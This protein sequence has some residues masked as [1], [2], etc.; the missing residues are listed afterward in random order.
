[1]GKALAEIQNRPL[2]ISLVLGFGVGLAGPLLAYWAVM[3]GLPT[4]DNAILWLWL[5]AVVSVASLLAGTAVAAFLPSFL[6]G[7]TDRAASA[8]HAWIGAREVRRM[9]GSATAAM[10]IPTTPEEAELW[11]ATQPDTPRLRP[12]RFEM[13]LLTRRFDEARTAA[14]HFAGD[15]PLDDYRRAECLAMVDDQQTGHADLT[16]TRQALARIPRGID[17]A[18][19]T[20]SLAVFEARRLVGRGDWRTPLV[21]ARSQVPGSDWSILARDM[22]WPIFRYLAPRVVLPVA[23]L[24]VVISLMV[25]FAV[26]I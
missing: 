21:N 16:D 20:A 9:F 25:T 14:V 1:L 11:L 8:L 22:G 19:A 13:L 18:E 26:R 24:I 7:S 4:R 17:R 15:T 2:T 12:L 10:A 3:S 6:L 23:A 5:A